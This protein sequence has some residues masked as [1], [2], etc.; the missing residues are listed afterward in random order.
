MLKKSKLFTIAALAA[1]IGGHLASAQDSALLDLLVKKKVITEQEAESTQSQ[2]AKE[3]ASASA[4]KFNISTPV[5][6]I[7]L[8]GDARLRYEWREGQA[9]GYTG[10][11]NLAGYSNAD[12]FRYRLRL[13]ADVTLT[14]QWFLGVR[15]ETATNARSTNVTYGNGAANGAP[16]GKNQGG[17]YVGQAYLKYTPFDWLIL[18]GGKIPNPFVTTPLVWDPDINPEG[19]AEQFKYTI[20]SFGGTADKVSADGKSGVPASSGVTVDLFANFGQFIYDTA[21]PQ[22]AYGASGKNDTWLFG[23][24]VGAKANFCKSTYLQVA[25]TLYNYSGSKGNDFN[26][27]YSGDPGGNQTGINDLLVLDIPAEFGWTAFNLPF[28]IFG[29]F[30][31]NIDGRARAD[32]ANAAAVR[33]GTGKSKFA[34]HAG[35]YDS[36]AWQAGLSVGKIKKKGDYSLSAYYQYSG[37]YSLDP[38]LIDN[39]IF[40]GHLN[41]Q[42]VVFKAGYAL[43]DA[44]TINLSYNHG[45]IINPA[46]G[47][48][49]NGGTLSGSSVNP[50]LRDYNLLQADVNIKF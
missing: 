35:A 27:I 45:R 24:Q 39:D 16:F 25:P 41:L 30:A 36:L 33:P 34:S 3:Y 11:T 43:T 32:A 23:Y 9:G 38:N 40:D 8:Y 15:L 44:V 26:A 49:G 18:T 2:L 48:G 31:Y 37:A 12:Q 10:S 17:I 28:S 46:L 13:G 20:G 19:V 7:R 6:Q 47:T 4:G 1:L 50:S 14:D 29:D 42:G 22:N 21:T 5:K